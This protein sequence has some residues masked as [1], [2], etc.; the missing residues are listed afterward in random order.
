MKKFIITF[1]LLAV[2]L[3][4]VAGANAQELVPAKESVS[5]LPGSFWYKPKIFW[6]QV[7]QKILGDSQ[8]AQDYF[9]KRMRKR[10]AEALEIAKTKGVLSD[11][12]IAVLRSR[13]SHKQ[14][15]EELAIRNAY[16]APITTTIEDIEERAA[17]FDREYLD[18]IKKAKDDMELEKDELRKQIIAV[19][20]EKDQEKLDELTGQMKNLVERGDDLREREWQVKS[21]GAGQAEIIENRLTG[22]EKAQLLFKRIEREGLKNTQ[23]WERLR[24]MLQKK[25]DKESLDSLTD[26]IQKELNKTLLER[27]A[28]EDAAEEKKNAADLILG[29]AESPAP[30]PVL[31]TIPSKIVSTERLGLVGYR[32]D[33]AGEVGAFFDYQLEGVGGLPPYHFQ[34][35]TGYGFPPIGVI[36]DS[37]GRLSGIPQAAGRYSFVLCIV[38]TTGAYN[39]K[40]SGMIV[41][42]ATRQAFPQPAPET[43]PA[44]QPA[45]AATAKFSISSVSCQLTKEA[46]VDSEY[47]VSVSGIASGPINARLVLPGLP[48]Y[49]SNSWTSSWGNK[50]SDIVDRSSSDPETTNWTST[51]VVGRGTKTISGYVRVGSDKI[52]DSRTVVCQ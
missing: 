23:L 44:P 15:A 45:P 46:G 19:R 29:K 3:S 18:L 30:K 2:T 24:S 4:V 38:D 1:L 16:K 48:G 42:P 6:E 41:G 17:Q 34:L 5:V 8:A 32:S 33:F 47:T 39:C 9:E 31:K 40:Q 37:N 10:E 27:K 51:L 22:A 49:I 14:E 13:L 21:T 11:E 20:E 36:F 12:A 26:E 43:A 50:I 52:S 35:G 25:S 28:D 7:W